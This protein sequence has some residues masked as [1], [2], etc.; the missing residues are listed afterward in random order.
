M[1][2]LGLGSNIGFPLKNLRTAIHLLQRLPNLK[3]LKISSVYISDAELPENAP[4]EWNKS[5][6]NLAILCHSDRS[7]R[8]L[9]HQLQQIEEQIGRRRDQRW[10]PRLIDIDILTWGTLQYQDEKLTIPHRSL[11][12]RPF[13]LLPLLE[14]FPEFKTSSLEHIPWLKPQ[15][16]IPF[17]T[18]TINACL[19]GPALMG[20]VNVTPD[21]FS[22]G[23]LF[24]TLESQ[25]EQIKT[26]ILGG[27]EVIDIGAESTRP[28]ATP[29]S[30]KEEWKRLEPLLTLVKNLPTELGIDPALIPE[31][32]L[33]TYHPETVEKAIQHSSLQ[34]VNDVS[35][36]YFK[37]I[38]VLLKNTEIR[39][40]TM[41]HLGVPPSAQKT[42]PLDQDP[43]S[44][45][46]QWAT[47]RIQLL[48][49][50]GLK[51]DQLIV[52]PGI[53]FGL[54]PSQNWEVLKRVGEL[55]EHLQSI[56]IP[57][58]VGHSR[59]SFLKST[60]TED[61]IFARD[62]SSSL[63]AFCLAEKK[64]DY[65]RIHAVSMANQTLK[66]FNKLNS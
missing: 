44:W 54:T 29:V 4:P 50:H 53:G 58:L 49:K 20:I 63:I 45:I 22:D 42:I 43:V 11:L 9:S 10:E 28:N 52:D 15:A 7:P 51:T 5:Y 6:L 13:A 55:K 33:D 62:L 2:G 14:I 37:D 24:P 30:P 46:T 8:E 32:S 60:L 21:S 25:K 12:T 31:I 47:S 61:T 59:K 41:H 57:I 17:N 27:A 39:Y 35:G 23:N 40:V 65:L 3:I 34:W 48:Q 66:I 18:R 16:V 38:A 36:E 64:I 19:S 1:I 56:N 26:L